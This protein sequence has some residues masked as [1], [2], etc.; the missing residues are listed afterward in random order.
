MIREFEFYHGAVIAKLLHEA[1]SPVN[2]K[3]FPTPSNASYIL[4]ENIGLYI[5][6]SAKRMS[7]WR[8]SFAKE[9]QDEILDMRNKLEEVYLLLACGDDGIVILS[10]DE[11]KKLLNETHVPVEWISISR[12]KRTEYT[13][14]GTD[15]ALVHKVSKQD[16]PRKIF[17]E[18]KEGEKPKR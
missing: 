13:V 4:N 14:K 3:P 16:F 18:K 5:K 10:F 17:E 7:P 6:H 1:G 12:S 11:V 2:I 15:G 9:H 8:F